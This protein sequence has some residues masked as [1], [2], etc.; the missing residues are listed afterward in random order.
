MDIAEGRKNDRAGGQNQDRFRGRGGGGGGMSRGGPPSYNNQGGGGGGGGYNRGG[1]GYP[2]QA[3]MHE[4]QYGGYNNYRGNRGGGGGGGIGGGGYGPRG[5]GGGGGRTGNNY[6]HPPHDRI[7]RPYNDEP[8]GGGGGGG[9]GGGQGYPAPRPR[10]DSE[11]SRTSVSED[12]KEPTPGKL[13]FSI[14]VSTL[15]FRLYRSSINHTVITFPTFFLIPGN[16]KQL[17]LLEDEH[18]W[19]HLNS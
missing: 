14:A 16:R 10:R 17:S 2:N 18:F 9:G 1:G 7:S 19:Y 8:R 4:D 15:L 3:P 12:F 6:G 13:S 11:R 5:S